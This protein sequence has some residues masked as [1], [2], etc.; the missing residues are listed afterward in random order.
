MQKSRNFFSC[1]EGDLQKQNFWNL[2]KQPNIKF[3]AR[4]KN[5]KINA[6]NPKDRDLNRDWT[7]VNFECFFI[8]SFSSSYVHF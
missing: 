6:T 5:S 1:F 8:N 2:Q 7:I 3:A 4:E